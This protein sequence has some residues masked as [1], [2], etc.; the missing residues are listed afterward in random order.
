LNAMGS[1]NHLPLTLFDFPLSSSWK[2]PSHHSQCN[3]PASF[4]TENPEAPTSMGSGWVVQD[5]SHFVLHHCSPQA[6]LCS[7]GHAECWTHFPRPSV[8]IGSL[9]DNQG[10][11]HFSKP[12]AFLGSPK[13]APQFEEE[14]AVCISA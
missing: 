5:L 14:E 13:Q 4:P 1:K 3:A 7:K 11:Q 12:M 9:I 10:Q 8:C 2:R 6:I